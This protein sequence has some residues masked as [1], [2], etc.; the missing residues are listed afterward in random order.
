ME[1]KKKGNTTNSKTNIYV[2]FIDAEFTV[3]F[4][5]DDNTPYE[6]RTVKSG[7]STY[8]PDV[9]PTPKKEEHSGWIFDS[10]KYYYTDWTEYDQPG[11]PLQSV[12]TDLYAVAQFVPDPEMPYYTITFR[13]DDYSV[14]ETKQVAEGNNALLPSTTPQPK[15]LEHEGWI[16]SHWNYYDSTLGIENV[17]EDRN[18][19]AVF[20]EPA[21]NP[22]EP[23]KGVYTI[24]FRYDDYSIFEIKQV[25]EGN[26]GLLP[27]TTPQPK[28]SEHQ[29]WNFSHW[30]YYD[31]TLG[32]ENVT[33][34]RNAI[35]VFTAAS[36]N[37][38]ASGNNPGSGSSGNNNPNN[39]NNNNNSSTSNNSASNNAANIGGRYNVVVENGA[40]G[41]YY[42][43]GGVV[44]ITAYAAPSG[45]V[46]DRWTTS[47]AD[48]GFSNAFGASTTFIM[49]S[50]D[51][52]VTATYKI[53]SAS[54]NR[55]S[56]NGT[57]NSTNNKNSNTTSGSG[58]TTRNP[59]GGGT[60]VTVTTGTIDNNNKNLASATVS[61]ST[62]NF[63]V[64]IT[65]SA[66]ASAAVEQALRAQYGDLSNIRFVG[67]DISLYDETGTRKIENTAGLAVN[68]TIPIPDDL[69]PY[70]GNN[71]AAGVVNGVLDP[72]AVK[73]TTIDGVPCMQFTATHFSPYAIY[74]NTNNLVSGVTDTTPKTGD[75]HPKWFLAIGLACISGVLFTWK[76][77]KKVPV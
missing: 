21:V 29:G 42:A 25:A 76:D 56:Q 51:V 60:D 50:H 57:T 27:S 34:D 66:A 59:S 61:G 58:T 33:E 32:L 22:G 48:I 53:P 46:F 75:I 35:A 18:A 11:N 44:T 62:D 37:G 1:Q 71:M 7:F 30:N 45:K 55:V 16:F 54:S 43:P 19:I 68:I 12:T 72:M 6:E 4:L 14:F 67:F 26:N 2:H 17:T 41:G 47:N 9:D 10:W 77:K 38:D 13:Y 39:G 63:V 70:A 64:K 8:L 65:D 73:F 52:K 15:L 69:V 40:G 3:S 28:L 31:S 49:P 24:T 20:V 5:N 74:V 36:G 23:E